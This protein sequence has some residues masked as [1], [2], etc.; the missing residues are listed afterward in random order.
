V[1][2]GKTGLLVT[3]QDISGFAI[4]IE[5]VLSNERWST[6]VRQHASDWV[7]QNFSWTGVAAQLSDLYCHQLATSLLDMSRASRRSM[8]P[9]AARLTA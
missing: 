6:Q 5:E 7:Q 8:V 3:P 4:A 2:P 1:V 9:A